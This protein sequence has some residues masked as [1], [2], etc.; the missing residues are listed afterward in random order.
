MGEY[1]CHDYL[2]VDSNSI[3]VV[4]GIIVLKRN[5]SDQILRS[6]LQEILS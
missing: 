1:S 3:V 6:I 4:L 2:R 5:D